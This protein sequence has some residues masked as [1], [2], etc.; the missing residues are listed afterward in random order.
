MLLIRLPLALVCFAIAIV[1]AFVPGPA[2]VFWILGLMLL[3]F[4]VGQILMSI[5]RGQDLLDRHVPPA[6]R[7]PRFRLRHM[8][9]ILRHRWIQALDRLS[10]RDQIRRR[11][12][13]ERRA[14]REH[15]RHRP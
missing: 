6:R 13:A 14:L 1:L 10:G 9:A 15:G 8:K 11:R 5:R 12:R 4:S 2:F 7:L 3:G